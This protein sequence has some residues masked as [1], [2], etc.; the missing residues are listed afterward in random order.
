MPPGRSDLLARALAIAA[1]PEGMGDGGGGRGGGGGG[2]GG[3]DDGGD[4]G[5]EVMPPDPEGEGEDPL[6]HAARAAA[7]ARAVAEFPCACA[8]VV[9][10]GWRG[11][12]VRGPDRGR[13]SADDDTAEGKG[14]ADDTAGTAEGWGL[15]TTRQG[16]GC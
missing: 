2:K 12:G 15:L 16:G 3:G 11:G 10:R 8:A 13:V 6:T 4:C 7:C 14:A 5:I 9:K 1:H